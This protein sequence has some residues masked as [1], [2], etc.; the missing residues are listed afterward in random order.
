MSWL[1]KAKLLLLRQQMGFTLIEVLVAVG[2]LAAIGIAYMTALDTNYRSDRTLDE[3]V[4]ATNLATEYIE[5]IK[6][7]P[8]AHDNYP[9]AGDNITLPFQYTVDIVTECSSDGETFGPCTGSEDETFQK[10]TVNISREGR[11]VLS[12]CEYRTKR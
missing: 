7:L 10:I 11:P 1:K 2:I 6:Q 8:F 4:T 9:N 5:A 12:M 3:K